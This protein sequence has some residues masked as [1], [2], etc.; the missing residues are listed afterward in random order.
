MLTEQQKQ[1]VREHLKRQDRIFNTLKKSPKE[2]PLASSEQFA[3]EAE[4]RDFFAGLEEENPS[5]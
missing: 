2:R 3:S 4:V 5:A 1:K